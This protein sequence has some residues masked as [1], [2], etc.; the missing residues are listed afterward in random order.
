MRIWMMAAL[1]SG[2]CVSIAIAGARAAD[3]EA[4]VPLAPGEAAGPWTLESAGRAICVIKLETARSGAGYAAQSLSSCRSML[5][6]DPAG[7]QP[8]HDG[9]RLVAADGGSL[10]GFSRWSNS[11][12]VSHQAS[13]ADVQ[14]RRGR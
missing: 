2:L 14:L 12:F 4:G 5:A 8:T 11:L 3:N 1:A 6:S 10:L 7:W 13:G 9:M